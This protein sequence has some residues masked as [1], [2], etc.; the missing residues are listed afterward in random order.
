MSLTQITGDKMV[1]VT[2]C[3]VFATLKRRYLYIIIIII[4]LKDRTRNRVKICYLRCFVFVLSM[5]VCVGGGGWGGVI[6]FPI[7]RVCNASSLRVPFK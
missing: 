6:P 1:G 3:R 5:C 7:D 4:F 2:H